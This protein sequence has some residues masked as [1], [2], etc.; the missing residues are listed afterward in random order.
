MSTLVNLHIGG[1]VP[2][3][4]SETIYELILVSPYTEPGNNLLVLRSAPD[5]A[6]VDG[7]AAVVESKDA[8]V[9]TATTGLPVDPVVGTLAVTGRSDSSSFIG[10]GVAPGRTGTWATTEAKDTTVI[11]GL[12][13]EGIVPR[14]GILNTTE[15][16]DTSSVSGSWTMKWVASM[17]ATG[18]GDVGEIS[19]WYVEYTGP[20]FLNVTERKDTAA[21]VG[22]HTYPVAGSLTATEL[23]DTAAI[24]GFTA[25]LVEA[26]STDTVVVSEALS[27]IDV[28]LSLVDHCYCSDLVEEDQHTAITE[29]VYSSDYLVSALKVTQ[30]LSESPVVRDALRGTFS[31]DLTDTVTAS[32][33]SSIL[34][35][36]EK[37]DRAAATDL[38]GSALRLTATWTDSVTETEILQADYSVAWADTAHASETLSGPAVFSRAL[39][40]TITIRDTLAASLASSAA[41]ADR[42]VIQE[43][44][45]YA[46]MASTTD[47]LSATEVQVGVIRQIAPALVDGVAAA[48]TLSSTMAVYAPVLTDT[49]LSAD[50]VTDV[51]LLRLVGV[52]S[53]TVLAGDGLR[54][55]AQTLCVVNAE[56]G[57]VS[58]YTLTPVV[59]SLASFRG[60][61]YLAGPDGLYAMDAETDGDGAVVWTVQT[62]FSDLGTDAL[63]RIRDVNIQ[64]RTAGDTTV[65]VTSDRCGEKQTWTYR[66]PPVTRTAYRDGVVKI[67]KG[68]ASVYCALGLQGIGPAELDQVRVVVEPLSRRR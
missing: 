5:I 49:G 36:Q 54:E 22:R 27:S 19:T 56:T 30:V 60:T 2:P 61:L 46:W 59:T 62:G 14:T 63:K 17:A 37:E 39:Q 10:E 40:D 12:G 42:G 32:D 57:A 43:T 4:E 67:G 31:G 26:E 7:T 64:C 55:S 9:F 20:G 48:I 34:L 25:E 8:G 47:T 38:L 11:T 33:F 44:L 28:I 51:T 29:R 23:G 13:Y 68:I 35:E 53:D 50:A 6:P 41:L 65:Q 58:T 45:G 16:P 15:A 66:L 24:I 21:A 18:P 52:L 3:S 1:A